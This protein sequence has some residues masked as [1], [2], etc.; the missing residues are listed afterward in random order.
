MRTRFWRSLNLK[1]E[2]RI[3]LY[4]LGRQYEKHLGELI[5]YG[6]TPHLTL[7]VTAPAVIG[8]LNLTPTRIQPEADFDVTL[9]WPPFRLRG[10]TR[11]Y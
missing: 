6:F 7:F 1:E 3:A 4:R 11:E 10:G 8:D 5:G 9:K 2:Q